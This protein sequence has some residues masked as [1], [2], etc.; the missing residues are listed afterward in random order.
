VRLLEPSFAGIN[1]KDIA[2]PQGLDVYDGLQQQLGIP[3]FHENLYAPAIV[4]VAA[5]INALDLADKRIDAVRVAV[6]G[7]GTVGLGCLR[8]LQALGMSPDQFTLF[9]RDGL[10]HPDR[11]DLSPHQRRFARHAGGPDAGCGHARRR[12]LRGCVRRPAS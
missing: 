10:V 2:A 5:L 7:A 9:D 11:A 6:A 1:L 8:L 3:V 4:V 12:R